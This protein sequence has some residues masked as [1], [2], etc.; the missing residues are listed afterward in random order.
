MLFSLFKVIMKSFENSIALSKEDSCLKT[1]YAV[2]NPFVF[3]NVTDCTFP[4]RL[5]NAL[6]KQSMVAYG[7]TFNT[8]RVRFLGYSGS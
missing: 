4:H 3:E 7:G 6:L 2:L 8:K 1:I 5:A